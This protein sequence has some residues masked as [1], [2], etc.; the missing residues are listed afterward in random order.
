MPTIAFGGLS[1]RCEGCL[2][3]IN[4]RVMEV[5]GVQKVEID[6]NDVKVTGNFDPQQVIIHV[7]KKTKKTLTAADK[8]INEAAM[9]KIEKMRRASR[10][11]VDKSDNICCFGF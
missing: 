7:W 2:K 4:K 8:G 1:C 5:S 10:A 6:S 9:L 3:K 11:T